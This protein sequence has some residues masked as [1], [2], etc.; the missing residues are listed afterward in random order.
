[1]A[2]SSGSNLTQATGEAKDALAQLGIALRDQ[3]GNLRGREHL[4]GDVA[5]AF[6]RIEVPAERV[7][8]AFKLFDSEGVALVNLLR[9]GSDALEEMRETSASCW[10][11]TSCAMRSEPV[12][13]STR[14]LRWSRRI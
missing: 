14:S 1:M 4:L 2:S 10:T 12:L 6:A 5:D 8:L 9:N 11:S 13:S 7:R 3:G